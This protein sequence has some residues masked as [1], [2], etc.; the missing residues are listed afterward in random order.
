MFDVGTTTGSSI[1]AE[2][3]KQERKK[4]KNMEKYKKCKIPEKQKNTAKVC[5]LSPH[6]NRPKKRQTLLVFRGELVRQNCKFHCKT[7]V[8]SGC[9]EI[10]ISKE[11]C[12]KNRF[13]RRKV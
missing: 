5:S 8:D 12:A 11:V 9:E 7:L 4:Y 6:K 3:D 1:I 2:G 10:V 13:K